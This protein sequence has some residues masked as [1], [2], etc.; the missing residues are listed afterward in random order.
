MASTCAQRIWYPVRPAFRWA[1]VALAAAVL[2]ACGGGDDGNRALSLTQEAEDRRAEPRVTSR[3]FG[4]LRRG[5]GPLAASRRQ[6][7]DPAKTTVTLKR[8]PLVSDPTATN[9][10]TP[11][12]RS[13][14]RVTWGIPVIAPA[15]SVGLIASI[16][17][18]VPSK[19][20]V[21]IVNFYCRGR[22]VI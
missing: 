8:R 6:R 16:A 21:G 14:L 15:R 9:S 18:R 2:A 7:E 12:L 3:E 17:K 11:P 22:H 5:G 4:R 20:P 19:I 13:L 10:T 1:P